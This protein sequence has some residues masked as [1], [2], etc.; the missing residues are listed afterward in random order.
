MATSEV[1]ICNLALQK[2]GAYRITS[3]ADNSVEARA[4][5]ACYELLRDKE[6]RL[7]LWSFAKTRAILAPSSVAPAFTYT[8]AFPLPADFLRLVKPARIGLDWQT[9]RHE[10]ALAILT[11]DGD[12][13]EVRYISKVTNPALFNPCFVEM[14]ACKIA[15]HCC[16]AL[17]QSNTKK[18]AIMEEYLEA[19][20]DAK[21]TNA[22]ELSYQPE[23]VDNW[24]TARGSGQL[25][26]PEWAEE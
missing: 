20:K 19:K 10:G 25:V 4:V 8:Y 15:W 2:L 7:Y 6:L 26:G 5:S 24:I 22:F 1:S 13:L 3:L 9:E 16:E 11:N 14:L 21:R 23:P 12:T 17:T 18:V